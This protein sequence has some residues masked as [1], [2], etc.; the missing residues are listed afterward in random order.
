MLCVQFPVAN[1]Y[2]CRK[3]NQIFNTQNDELLWDTEDQHKQPKT[4][5]REHLSSVHRNLLFGQA[6][7][8]LKQTRSAVPFDNLP[9]WFAFNSGFY[10]FKNLDITGADT[11]G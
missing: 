2:M 3:P 11:S 10:H 9:L 6:V 1:T 5:F 4:R 7:G 8:T